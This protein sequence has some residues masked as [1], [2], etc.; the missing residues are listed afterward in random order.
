[1][2]ILFSDRNHLSEV[3][4]YLGIYHQNVSEGITC[5]HEILGF[6]IIFYYPKERFLRRWIVPDDE[7][8]R[9]EVK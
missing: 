5:I 8:G 3:W 2:G 4:H 7:L 9:T 6:Q 1:M